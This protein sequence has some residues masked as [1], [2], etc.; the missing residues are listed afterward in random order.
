MNEKNE[1]LDE[2]L[3]GFF[4]EK[5]SSEARKDILQGDE[6]LHSFAPCEAD[7]AVVDGIKKRISVKLNSR[8]VRSFRSIGVRIA[9]VAAVVI[10]A[11]LGVRVSNHKQVNIS[12]GINTISLDIWN[13]DNGYTGNEKTKIATLTEDI[14]SLENNLGTIRMDESE[15]DTDLFIDMEIEL[16]DIDDNFWKGK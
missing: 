3:S 13:G 16:E 6:L 1:N 14:D 9:A 15:D 10:F 8:S 4:D 5:K 12:S 7:A 11:F 2:L